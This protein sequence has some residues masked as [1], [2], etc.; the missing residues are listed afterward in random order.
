MTSSVLSVWRLRTLSTGAAAIAL[1]IVSCPAWAQ[2]TAAGSSVDLVGLQQQ[3]KIGDSLI[4][5]TDKG[6][7][8]KGRFQGVT[9]MDVVVL[10]N[11]V[12]QEIPSTH[13]VRVQKR[14]NGVRL[15]AVIGAAVGFPLGLALRSWAHEYG[16]NEAGAFAAP[17]A[18]GT[19]IGIGVDALL[20]L[21]R[22]VYERGYG[23]RSNVSLAVSPTSRAA[24]VTIS[25]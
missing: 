13:I 25:F 11:G 22:T 19:A 14:H 23:I 17:I 12:R 15:G 6:T 7:E 16:G 8:V 5:D 10:R 21:P 1:L 4:V 9:A 2:D 24:R 20:V 18:L 3:L